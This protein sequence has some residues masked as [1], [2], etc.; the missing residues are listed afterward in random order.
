MTIPPFAAEILRALEGAGHEAYC[1][2]GCVRDTLLGRVPEDWD[3]ATSARPEETLALFGGDALPTGLRHGTVTVRRGEGGAEVTTFRRDGGYADHRRPESVAFTASLAEDLARR[4]FTVNAMALS[5]RGELHDPFG[6]RRDL[7]AKC[8][9]CVGEPARR[10]GEDA[11]RILRG[12]RFAAVLD[13]SVEPATAA[14]S[15]ARED[16]RFI[17]PERIFTEVRKLLLAPRPSPVLRRFPE[18]FGVFWPELL[19][20]PGYDQRNF[21]HCYDLWEHTLH[22]LDAAPAEESLRFAALLHD[23]GKPACFSLDADGVGHFYGHAAKSAELADAM[24]ARLRVPNALRQEVGELIRRHDTPLPGIPEANLRRLLRRLGEERLR[25]LI[26]LQRADNLAQAPAFR[27]ERSAGLDQV[28]RRLDAL[29]AEDACFSLRQLAVNGRDLLALGL[30]GPEIGAAL[31]LL[32][33]E[34]VEGRA[35]ND[36]EAL[37]ALLRRRMGEGL[38]PGRKGAIVG[39]DIESPRR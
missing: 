32:L 30:R 37:L 9:R 36:R 15:A 22:A 35:P 8:I 7:E 12:L 31:D 10:F 5:L 2:G 14:L 17:A 25:R 23:V 38:R 6:G 1:V 39:D 19:P 33:N 20:M 3:I 34:V 21:H 18:V 27:A 28:L 26:A 29:L 11:L 16:L 4:D 24:L 13:F